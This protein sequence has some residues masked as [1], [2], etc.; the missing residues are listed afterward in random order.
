MGHHELFVHYCLYHFVLDHGF[1]SHHF[2]SVSALILVYNAVNFAGR[3]IAYLPQHKNLPQGYFIYV[4][5]S[6]IVD[7]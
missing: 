4:L 3:S 5:L 2:E 7:V 1:L 6:P